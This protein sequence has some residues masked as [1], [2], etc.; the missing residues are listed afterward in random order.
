[1]C[2]FRFYP[3][4]KQFLRNFIFYLSV[5]NDSSDNGL[6]GYVFKEEIVIKL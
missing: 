2:F 3:H 6:E 5:M 4:K 1:M